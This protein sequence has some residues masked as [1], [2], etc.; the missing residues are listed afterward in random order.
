MENKKKTLNS[1]N[2]NI[3]RIVFKQHQNDDFCV[4]KNCSQEQF[5]KTRTKHTLNDEMMID[6]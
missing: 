5:L 3:I 6:D 2:K 4:F 1:D